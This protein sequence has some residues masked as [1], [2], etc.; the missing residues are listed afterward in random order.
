MKKLFVLLLVVVGLILGVGFVT[1]LARADELDDI[2]KQIN[3]LSKAREMSVAAT[4][5]LEAE[6][7]NLNKK[8]DVAEAGINKAK[9]ELRGLEASIAKRERDFSEQ[10]VLLAERAL[11]FYKSSR[12]PS[13]LFVLFSNGGLARDLFYSR[14]VTD[15]DKD[16]IAMITED[17][18]QLSRDKKKAEEDRVRLADL[19]VKLDKEADFFRGEIAGAKTYQ[20]EL[21]SQIASLSAKQQ[22]II[23]QRQAS[24]NLP[25]SLGAGTMMCT[26]DRKLDPGFGGALAFYT[27]GIPHRVGMN[28]YGAYGRA[29]AGQDYKEIL[30]AYFDG[31]SFE[32]GKQDI[33]IKIQGHGE[34]SLD[35]YLLGIYEMPESWD[36]N[37]LKAQ[38]VAARS[39]ALSYTNNGAN[40]ICTT[41]ACQVWKSDP[42]T[43]QWKQAVEQTKGEVMVNGGQVIKAWYSSTDGGYTFTSGDIWGG[44]KP[45]TKRLRDTNGDVGSFS[46]LNEKSY[47]KDSPC[48]YAAQGW[49][50]EY[51]NSAWLKPSEVAD[52]VNVLMLAKADSGTGDHLYQTDKPHPYGGEIWNEEKV[53]SELSSKG[54]TPFNSVSGVSVGADFGSGKTTSVNVSG[55]AGSK[56]FSGD[57]FK[58][59]FNIRAPANIQIVGPLYNV[60]R[61]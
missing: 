52:I 61:K 23:S 48:F 54:I 32:G 15:R 37:A 17:L 24:L 12:V 14:V 5:P 13:S 45:W 2:T 43:G 41:Q 29:K 38:A 27:Y 6:L 4:K 11:S 39:Y 31:I 60:E 9:E 28:Q 55:D 44:D 51:A 8:L 30:N 53:K 59:Y 36:M 42:K 1:S 33:K 49:R 10:Y 57:E 25:V 50:G 46:E 34:K 21:S 22:S 35:E 3:E 26:D 7:G 20:A 47:D 19:Q 40:E 16:E 18:I 58:S 56:S